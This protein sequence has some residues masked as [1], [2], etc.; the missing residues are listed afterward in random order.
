M[1]LRRWS[2]LIVKLL[3]T[4]VMITAVVVRHGIVVAVMCMHGAILRLGHH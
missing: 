2:S 4:K 3:S 1:R